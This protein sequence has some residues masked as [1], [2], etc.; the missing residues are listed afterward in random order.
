MTGP[1]GTAPPLDGN[2]F[3]IKNEINRVLH[4]YPLC[5]L[6]LYFFFLIWI[7]FPC[8]KEKALYEGSS[9]ESL[10]NSCFSFRQHGHKNDIPSDRRAER[11]YLFECRLPCDWLALILPVFPD[12]VWTACAYSSYSNWIDFHFRL[13]A[14]KSGL[15]RGIKSPIFDPVNCRYRFKR[16]HF[17]ET[18]IWPPYK[19]V[20]TPV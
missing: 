18:E 20:L 1:T 12:I 13:Y 17:I 19:I 5:E 8:G 9:H 10:A 11:A 4:P 3:L 2:T 14:N 16:K 15:Y 7:S 6:L